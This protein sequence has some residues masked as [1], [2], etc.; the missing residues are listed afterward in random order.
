MYRQGTVKWPPRPSPLGD[1]LPLLPQG[2]RETL[3][4][5]TSILRPPEEAQAMIRDAGSACAHDPVLRKRGYDYGGLL[6]DMWRLNLLSESWAKL[7]HAGRHILCSRHY[8][9]RMR[10]KLF[11]ATVSPTGLY[12]CA[13]WT[14]PESRRQRLLATQRRLAYQR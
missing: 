6:A 2:I 9:F 13:S 7:R 3:E 12:A 8:P 1:L 14:M 10:L 5:R 11:E 4:H